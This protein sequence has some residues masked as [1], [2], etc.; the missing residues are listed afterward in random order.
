MIFKK[1]INSFDTIAGFYKFEKYGCIVDMLPLFIYFSIKAKPL[2]LFLKNIIIEIKI[3]IK[4]NHIR[5]SMKFIIDMEYRNV[6]I[7]TLEEFEN[8]CSKSEN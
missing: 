3:L 5:S 8:K 6:R 4:N 7:I 1:I 2:I